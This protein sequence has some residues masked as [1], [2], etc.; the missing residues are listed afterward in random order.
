MFVQQVLHDEMI[1][2]ALIGKAN[3]FHHVGV[4]AIGTGNQKVVFRQHTLCDQSA[5]QRA[6]IALWWGDLIDDLL[7]LLVWK[8][9]DL[10]FGEYLGKSHDCPSH[11]G[12]VR[13]EIEF[14]QPSQFA[15]QIG[16][17]EI[18]DGADSLETLWNPG[19]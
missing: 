2:E 19:V 6:L 16:E 13:I 7:C 12:D 8:P 15:V 5:K 11:I 4:A 10:F 3:T 18:K 17:K 1:R 9:A 14:E